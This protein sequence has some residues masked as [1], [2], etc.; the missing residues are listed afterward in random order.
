MRSYQDNTVPVPHQGESAS[1]DDDGHSVGDSSLAPAQPF[2][3]HVDGKGGQVALSDTALG[4]DIGAVA[5]KIKGEAVEG[6]VV[7]VTSG[8]A[9][10]SPGH[11]WMALLDA[12]YYPALLVAAAGEVVA[13]HDP[14]CLA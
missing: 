1:V 14:P 10:A 9:R 5:L 8:M 11:H 7:G 12:V 3:L 6:Q 13:L 4:K 2:I